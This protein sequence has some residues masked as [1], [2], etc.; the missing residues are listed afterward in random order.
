MAKLFNK[1]SLPPIEELIS[2]LMSANEFL[3][4]EWS[5]EE[6]IFNSL[7]AVRTLNSHKKIA[8]YVNQ[9]CKLA[10]EKHEQVLL[11]EMQ[12]Q[13]TTDINN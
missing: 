1:Q 9:V 6:T 10:V 4:P 12:F 3:Y 2:T 11:L 7:H 5:K 8:N 13:L